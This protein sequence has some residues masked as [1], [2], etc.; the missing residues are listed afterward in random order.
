MFCNQLIR[1]KVGLK[2]ALVTCRAISALGCFTC[3]TCQAALRLNSECQQ[4]V[5][6]QQSIPGEKVGEDS[7][8]ST[9][10]PFLVFLVAY[11][12][13]TILKLPVKESNNMHFSD[14]SVL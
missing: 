7:R 13:Q 9:Y 3:K 1:E 10:I 14:P 12:V 6:A 5:I 11:T 2:T 8:K 4:V